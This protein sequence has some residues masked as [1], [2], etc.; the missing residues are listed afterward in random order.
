LGNRAEDASYLVQC[1]PGPTDYLDPELPLLLTAM[2]YFCQ[3]EGP[4]YRGI[5]GAG[6]AYDFYM[7]TKCTEGLISFSLYKCTDVVG[8]YKAAKEIVMNHLNGV[9]EWSEE[10]LSS[11]KSSLIFEYIESEKTPLALSSTSL[12][13]YYRNVPEGHTR[14]MIDNISEIKLGDLQPVVEKYMKPLFFN[15][16]VCSIVCPQA[17]VASILEEFGKIDKKLTA[18]TGITNSFLEKWD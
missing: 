8:A 1:T 11:A 14:R 7:D 4:F 5:R 3:T 6:Y 12:C 9:E 17:K 16:Y 18:V 13:S 15:E 2:Q 10:F